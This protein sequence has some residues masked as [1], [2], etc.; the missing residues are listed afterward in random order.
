MNNW[1]RLYRETKDVYISK[2][3]CIIYRRA[4]QYIDFKGKR[5]LEIGCG[6]GR[7]SYLAA[8]DGANYICLVDKSKVA[9]DKARY[10]FQN[11]HSRLDFINGDILKKDLNLGKFDVA[12]SEGLIEHYNTDEQIKLVRKHAQYINDQGK[13]I[14]IAPASLH[15]ND[16]RCLFPSQK[17]IYGWQKPLTVKK[18]RM[19]MEEVGIKIDF[20]DRF[21]AT[22]GI[23]HFPGCRYLHRIVEF[24]IESN[25]RLDTFFGGLIL[26]IGSL[27]K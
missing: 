17:R 15:W 21:C 25:S 1:D 13:I 19:L 12:V 16:I 8:L 6:L 18:I 26:A 27:E 14:I 24:P 11:I 23:F 2:T 7:F 20:V 22:Y 5:L 10:F 4:K 9:L 3:N